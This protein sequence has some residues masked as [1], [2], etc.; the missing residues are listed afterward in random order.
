MSSRASRKRRKQQRPRR[1]PRRPSPGAARSHPVCPLYRFQPEGDFYQSWIECGSP[2]E[3]LRWADAA[4]GRARACG[5][6]DVPDLARRMPYYSAVY[7][8]QV[9]VQAAYQL[10]QYIEAGTL[11]VQWADGDPITDVPVALMAPPLTSG[12][13]GQARR[14]LHGLHARCCLIIADDGVV[15]P[16]E[17]GEP[18]PPNAGIMPGGDTGSARRLRSGGGQRPALPAAERH[19]ASPR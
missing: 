1:A 2:G 19:I 7:G 3:T 12:S 11:P 14:A 18:G 15:I 8:R 4:I 5:Q 13:A 16:L 17:P 10:D 9:P 6:L